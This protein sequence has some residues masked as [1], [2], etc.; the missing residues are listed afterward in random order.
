VSE[1]SHTN[2]F[3]LHPQLAAD[4]IVVTDLPLCR[5]LLMDDAQ[6]P[7]CILVP[8]R[9]D[10]REI[11]EL[12]ESDRQQLMRESCGVAERMAEGFHAHKMNVAALGNLVPQLH[13]HHIARFRHDPAWPAP[14]WGRLPRKPYTEEEWPRMLERM[15]KML[16]GCA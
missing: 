15:R 8:R 7:W 5:V 12:D 4:G 9:P 14:I 1:N 6:Y 16:R 13:I 3:E 11:H 2:D 10:L